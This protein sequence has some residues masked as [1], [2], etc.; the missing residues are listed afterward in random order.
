MMTTDTLRYKIQPKQGRKHRQ[1]FL[2]EIASADV[3]HSHLAADG[4]ELTATAESMIRERVVREFAFLHSCMVESAGITDIG[5][6]AIY[7]LH[8]Q[9]EPDSPPHTLPVE[10]P[11]F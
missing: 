5:Q 2:I 3:L 6:I 4:T 1:L 8:P 11:P 9:L 10:S 7:I